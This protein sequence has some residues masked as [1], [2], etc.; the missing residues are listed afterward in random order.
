GDVERLR[1]VARTAAERV[2]VDLAAVGRAALLHQRDA[3]ERLQRANEYGAGV[4]V[5]FSNRIEQEVDAVVQIDVRKA[6]RTEERLAARRTSERRVA[7]GII[8]AD[9]GLGL[10]DDAGRHALTRAM[11][12]DFAEQVLG[13]GERRSCVEAVFEDLTA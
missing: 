6:G 12:E 5:G 9:V 10:D 1:Q 7:G 8:L 2:L 11:D 3:V 13:N 4:S